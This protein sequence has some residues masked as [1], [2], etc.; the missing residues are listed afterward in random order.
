VACPIWFASLNLAA[1]EAGLS[2]G[3][4]GKPAPPPSSTLAPSSK[5]TST[6]DA[7]GT[8][9][10]TEPRID[11]ALRETSRFITNANLLT[12]AHETQK[13]D[14]E[15]EFKL[16]FELARRQRAEK[17]FTQAKRN[18]VALLEGRAPDD[19]KRAAMLE[20]ATLAQE[21]NEAGKAQQIYAQYLRRWPDDS[22]VPE[23]YLRQGLL[24][25]QMGAPTLALSKFYAVMNSA[26]TLKSGHVD[27]YQ[28]LVRHA[29]TEI[30]DTYYLDAK[31]EEAADFF[32]RLLKLETA[33]LN[34]RQ[35]QFKLVRCLASL[36]RN[37]ETIA[38]A[39][40]FAARYPEATETAEVRFIL[41]NA[42]QRSG[43]NAEA[44]KQVLLLLEVQQSGQDR[45]TWAYWQQRTGNDIANQLYLEGDY[46]SAL[47]IYSTLAALD[48]SPAWQLPAW[49]QIGLVY[50]RLQ[51]PRKAA[52]FY[53][54]IAA[55][56]NELDSRASPNLRTILD[57]ARWRMELLTWQAQIE[58]PTSTNTQAHLATPLS[59]Q[60]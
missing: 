53:N 27:Y 5:S 15:H 34:K 24:Y 41:A 4:G 8:N 21:N 46:L 40:D 14:P 51:Q 11:P 36:G 39:Q 3:V 56:E 12:S 1:Q 16:L 29:Q 52:E 35:V 31:Y 59:R 44:L 7:S 49:Y 57:M 26:L 25:R 22:S 45:R 20:L 10:Q 17:S 13:L 19:L 47:Q 48:S 37:N 33:A 2:N 55:R 30:A 23:V 58:R 28:G 43:Q 18:L 32:R 6:A 42:L 54:R 9:A 50:E 38:Q 60:P